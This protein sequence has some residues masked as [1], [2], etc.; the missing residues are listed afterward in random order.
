MFKK[1]GEKYIF[2]SLMHLDKRVWIA[3]LYWM[4]ILGLF[5]T[6]VLLTFKYIAPL[7]KTNVFAYFSWGQSMGLNILFIFIFVFFIFVK[8]FRRIKVNNSSI[9]I[10]RFIPLLTSEV[11]LSDVKKLHIV[12]MIYDI[13]KYYFVYL[14]TNKGYIELFYSFHKEKALKFAEELSEII[15]KE[16][17]NEIT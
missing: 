15:K 9:K 4:F 3:F 12:K 7:E 1:K 11:I 13:K 6:F 8:V 2:N 14:H 17:L 5:I 10:S 16:I